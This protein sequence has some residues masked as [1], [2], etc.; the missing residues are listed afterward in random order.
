MKFVLSG[1]FGELSQVR[2]G[3]HTGIDLQMETG[4]TLRSLMDGKV[5]AVRDYGSENIG[6]GVVIKTDDGNYHIFGHMDKVTVSKGDEINGGDV[7]GLSGNTGD[8]T[9]PHLHFGIQDSSGNFVDPT[10]Y[11]EELASISGDVPGSVIMSVVSTVDSQGFGG[12]IL[13]KYNNFAEG[14]INA[15]ME[16]VLKPIGHFIKFLTL[17]MW[18]WFVANLP[19]IM[20]YTTMAAGVFV[21]LSAM[22]GKGGMV[23]TLAWYFGF[24]ILATCILAGQ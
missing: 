17:E 18:E 6:K 14:A 12:W 16:W 20:G 7:I 3:K 23:K 11:G 8:S 10:Q 19:E 5:Y 1:A 24:F 9:G 21:I 22:V 2:D 15:E 4:T 13:D